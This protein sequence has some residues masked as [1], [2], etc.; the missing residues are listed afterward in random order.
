[1]RILAAMAFACLVMLVAIPLFEAF[2]HFIVNPYWTLSRQDTGLRSLFEML[3]AL[4]GL[5]FLVHKIET[6]NESRSTPE[7]S[8]LST[9][10]E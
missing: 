7:K 10:D 4:F 5:I 3:I 9:E 2:D 8:K 1:M 6:R